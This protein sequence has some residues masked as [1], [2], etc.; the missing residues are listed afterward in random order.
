MVRVWP[1]LAFYIDY[2]KNY[3]YFNQKAKGISI[4]GLLKSCGKN[5]L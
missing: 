1:L 5:C 2:A 4:F 3:I